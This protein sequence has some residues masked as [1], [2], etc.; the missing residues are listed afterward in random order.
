MRMD[1]AALVALAAAAA[2]PSP[3]A[4]PRLETL[5]RLINA[6][7]SREGLPT[8]AA[9]PALHALAAEWADHLAAHGK[10]IH[11]SDLRR[12]MKS[13]NWLA[14]SENLHFASTPLN[15]SSALD[16]W[17]RSPPHRRNLLDP[18]AT[19]MGLG[20]AAASDGRSFTVFNAA[21][22][23]PAGTLP[24][25]PPSAVTGLVAPPGAPKPSPFPAR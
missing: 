19:H 22:I 6:E 12:L 3:V 10:Q 13:N 18:D 21:R 24:P 20:T 11:R 4:N 17:L 25:P 5:A 2:A 16:T 23:P 14:L 9:S 8:L 7:R 15:P 1:V